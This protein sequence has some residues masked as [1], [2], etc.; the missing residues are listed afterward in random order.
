MASRK[1]KTKRPTAKVVKDPS[2]GAKKSAA[3]QLREQAER[4]KQARVDEADR[5]YREFAKQI[6]EE[7][8]L[9]HVPQITFTNDRITKAGWAWGVAD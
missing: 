9:I 6:H 2:T 4:E 1:K 8:G 3:Q 5:R 7:F